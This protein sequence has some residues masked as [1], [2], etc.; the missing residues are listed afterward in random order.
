MPAE[1]KEKRLFV[2]RSDSISEYREVNIRNGFSLH[3]QLNSLIHDRNQ[4]EIEMFGRSLRD[5]MRPTPEVVRT[6]F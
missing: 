3:L 5:Q 2:C 1:R 4:F 6:R